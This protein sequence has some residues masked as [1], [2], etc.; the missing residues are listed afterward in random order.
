MNIQDL[1]DLA[2]YGALGGVF[3]GASIGGS[4]YAYRRLLGRRGEPGSSSGEHDAALAGRLDAL[5]A[6]VTELESSIKDLPT[7]EQID[8]ITH[9][10]HTV[11]ERV[12]WIEGYMRGTQAAEA[13]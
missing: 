8:R 6:R 11:G 5:T 3:V 13:A 1:V 9:A 4:V 12:A 10:V 2:E 7:S